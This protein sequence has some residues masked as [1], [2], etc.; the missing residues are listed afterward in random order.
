MAK[1]FDCTSTLYQYFGR[2]DW[3]GSIWPDYCLFSS[4]WKRSGQ[5]A[6]QESAT[7][8]TRSEGIV[9]CDRHALGLWK[10]DASD[11]LCQKLSTVVT[12]TRSFQRSAQP[13][14]HWRVSSVTNDLRNMAQLFSRSQEN[15]GRN[16][17]HLRRYLCQQLF[18]FPRKALIDSTDE[19]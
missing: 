3:L 1:S 13:D 18:F 8:A 19:A 2:R 12:A 6:K 11:T 16:L 7:L 14:N 10:C 9:R 15:I 5:V 4:T 17:G